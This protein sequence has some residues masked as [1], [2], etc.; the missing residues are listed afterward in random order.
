MDH[1]VPLSG[2]GG[3]CRSSG[4][5]VATGN[6]PQHGDDDLRGSDKPGSRASA[7]GDTT[8]CLG[9]ARGANDEREEFAQDVVGVPEFEEEILGSALV[10]AWVLGCDERECHGRGVEEVH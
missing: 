4:E 10:G 1:E 3:G 7:V 8:A 2:A 9:V 5:G 6:I